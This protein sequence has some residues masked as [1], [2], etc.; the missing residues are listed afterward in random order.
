MRDFTVLNKH[1]LLPV[2]GGGNLYTPYTNG[3]EHL[4]KKGSMITCH[5]GSK[6]LMPNF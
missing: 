5:N 4:K 6:R 2:P 1:H 3:G